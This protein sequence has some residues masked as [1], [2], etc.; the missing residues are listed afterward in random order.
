MKNSREGLIGL[1]LAVMM[2]VGCGSSEI[3]PVDVYPED[4]CAYCRMAVSDQRFAAEIISETRDVFKFDDIGCMENFQ[5][6]SASLKLAAQFVKD[7][8]TKKWVPLEDATIVNT[9]M[10]TPMG[11]GKVAFSDRSKAEE[12]LKQRPK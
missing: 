11:S 3:K 5:K 7:Y 8:E 9:N 1:I 10:F 4:M 12:F 6:K 2:L